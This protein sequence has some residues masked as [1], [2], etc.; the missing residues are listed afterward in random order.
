MLI[1]KIKLLLKLLKYPTTRPEMF[2]F[3]RA[4]FAAR[5]KVVSVNFAGRKIRMNDSVAFL[6]MCEEIFGREIYA[7]RSENQAP[8]IIDCGLNIG[9]ASLFWVKKFPNARITAFEPDPEILR[10]AKSNLEGY[11]VEIKE[12]A[13]WS[14]ET[15]LSFSQEGVSAGR[16]ESGG[17][18]KVKTLRLKDLLTEKIDFL[19]IDIEGAE[20]VVLRDCAENLSNVQNLFVEY[21][22]F[23]EQEQSLS[24]ILNILSKAGF[25]YYLE[26]NGIRSKTPFL[27]RSRM[28]DCDNYI[29]IFAYRV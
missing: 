25:R 23:V 9:L 17:N 7:F 29:N 24:E 16:L 1:Y 3:L 11:G 26:H 27:Y 13:V 22:S 21:H 19:K 10:L 4:F 14:S 20:T 5:N 15:E 28:N 8:R 6:V 12:R 2:A 18:I